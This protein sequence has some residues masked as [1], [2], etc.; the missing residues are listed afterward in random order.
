[1]AKSVTYRLFLKSRLYDLRLEE[2]GSLKGHLD[3]FS[4]IVM[5]IYNI[6]VVVDDEDL[7]IFLLCS[8]PS[9]YKNFSETLLYGREVLSSNNFKNALV[10]RDLIEKQLTSKGSGSS[11]GNKGKNE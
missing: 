4:T 2:G 11:E 10:Q 9:S 1:M 5:D 8:L 7:T 3:E 6:D